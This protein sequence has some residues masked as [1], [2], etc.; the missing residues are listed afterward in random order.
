MNLRK[1]PNIISNI[2]SQS[3]PFFAFF[4]SPRPSRGLCAPCKTC[5]G[6]PAPRP[7]RNPRPAR[8]AGRGLLPGPVPG[9]NPGRRVGLGVGCYPAPR[10]GET[11]PASGPGAAV[12]VSASRLGGA[13]RAPVQGLRGRLGPV[14][15][16]APAARWR[17]GR[18]EVPLPPPGRRRGAAIRASGVPGKGGARPSPAR[19]RG[20]W[21]GWDFGI[22]NG[23]FRKDGQHGHRDF[24]GRGV[25]VP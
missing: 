8:R 9:R 18:H 10:L 3:I 17:N 5:A 20:L 14:P 2:F 6:S 23:I 1:L 25:C 7:R 21:R 11:L 4:A 16:R 19:R 13:P 12:S 24:Q 15:G 22:L